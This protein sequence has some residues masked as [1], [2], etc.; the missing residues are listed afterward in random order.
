MVM[1]GLEARQV[2]YTFVKAY[3]LADLMLWNIILR[4]VCCLGRRA[5]IVAVSSSSA[6]INH[7][8][9]EMCSAVRHIS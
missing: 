9:L 4:L 6:D 1:K 7:F 3:V 8:H 2:V 5:G